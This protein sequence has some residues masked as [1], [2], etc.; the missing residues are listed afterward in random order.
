MYWKIRPLRQSRGPRGASCQGGCIFQFIRT[1][2]SVLPFF[3][4]ETGNYTLS[5]WVVLKVYKSNALLLCKNTP[6]EAICIQR[7]ERL[8]G[9]K[10]EGRGTQIAEGGVFSISC[11][12]EPVYSPRTPFVE[13]SMSRP[14]VPQQFFLSSWMS[15]NTALRPQLPLK[16]YIL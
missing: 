4:P 2:D 13:P 9:G 10:L 14:P 8:P 15:C 16:P 1:R 11:R 3:F 12:L 6:P 5:S 7:P